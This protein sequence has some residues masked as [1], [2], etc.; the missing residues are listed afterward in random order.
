M[1]FQWDDE[2]AAS[3]LAK[4]GVSFEEAQTAF[5]DPLYVDFFD[6]RH[7]ADEPRYILV[8]QSRPGR[9]LIISYTE[10]DNVTRLISARKVTPTEREAYEES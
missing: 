9:L 6:P 2:K 1:E 7:S 10:R 3:N 4:H 5:G 8:G